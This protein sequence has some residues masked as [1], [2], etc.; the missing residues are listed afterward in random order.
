MLISMSVPYL[1]DSCSL[2]GKTVLIA[3]HI[4]KQCV[5]V[6]DAT[7]RRVIAYVNDIFLNSATFIVYPKGRERVLKERRK[8]VHA[9]IRGTVCCKEEIGNDLP[10][11]KAYYN[12]YVTETFIDKITLEPLTRATLIYCIGKSVY[13]LH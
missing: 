2:S 5:S 8:N 11:K 1:I 10:W 3:Y 13:Y 9:F 6:R 12:P 4:P 7:T